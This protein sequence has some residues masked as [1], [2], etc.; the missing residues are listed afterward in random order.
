MC[1][2]HHFYYH[3][4][5]C[6]KC[7]CGRDCFMAFWLAMCRIA[8]GGVS[9]GLYYAIRYA[10]DD[11]DKNATNYY[12]RVS[13]VVVLYLLII[14]FAALAIHPV[15]VGV[16][17]VAVGFAPLVVAVCLAMH[18]NSMVEFNKSTN[19]PVLVKRLNQPYNLTI[20]GE[21]IPR[22]C[23][24]YYCMVFKPASC[25]QFRP[26]DEF[27]G[28]NLTD[29]CVI[30]LDALDSFYIDGADGPYCTTM[31]KKQYE[32]FVVLEILPL[33]PL[34]IVSAIGSIIGAICVY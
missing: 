21:E 18:I 27:R 15:F 19:E 4:C 13:G 14:G 22:Q 33:F 1:K 11:L 26:C 17:I 3:C 16:S 30:E 6:A 20:Y 31:A 28:K 2:L 32:G 9:V 29:T 10:T 5:L 24:K 23:D 7:W 25:L 34:S 12:M 8:C